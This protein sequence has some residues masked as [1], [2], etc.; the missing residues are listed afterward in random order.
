[1]IPFHKNTLDGFNSSVVNTDPT[2]FE[3]YR[4][5]CSNWFEQAEKYNRVYFVK[6]CT[7]SLE[8]ALMSL[9]LPPDSE[10][11]LPSYSFV[12]LAN[13]INN[14]GHKCI[15]VDCEKDTMNISVDSLEAAISPKTKA[16]VVINYAGVACDYDNLKQICTKHNLFLI[17]DNA[18]GIKAKY[19]GKLLGNFGDI[20][21]FSFDY[22]KNLNCY[23]GGAIIINRT[24][25]I[26]EFN[27]NYEFGTNKIEFLAGNS[28]FYEWR[29]KGS[30]SR[31]AP[32]LFPYLSFQLEAA[33]SII[34][35][36]QRKWWLYQ[37][38]LEPLEAEGKIGRTV[39]PEYAEHNCHMFWF[40]TAS[41]AERAKLIDYLKTRNIQASF[42]YTPLHPSKYG[43]LVGE[44]RG[45]DVNTTTES[46]K[47]LR[48]PLFYSLKEEELNSIVDAILAFYR[49]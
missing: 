32:P 14:L 16:V 2:Q 11:I 18:H 6:S 21:T 40:K 20:A 25:L 26:P 24:E 8:L 34:A 9:N 5:K 3:S 49:Q 10:V 19:K 33:E 22:L 41:I 28:T 44:F 12:S 42:H 7:Q 47:L 30:N 38:Y 37:K 35:E 17:E 1:M 46:E 31:L 39:L 23:E 4:I 13:A 15:F 43:K 27:I 36:F 45:E 48:L 29:G